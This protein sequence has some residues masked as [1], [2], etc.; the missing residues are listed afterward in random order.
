MKRLKVVSL[1]LGIAAAALL[2]AYPA[3]A[4]NT[5]NQPPGPPAA[6]FSNEEKG[7]QPR[8]VI[9]T[10]VTHCQAFNDGPGTIVFTAGRVG[11]PGKVNNNCRGD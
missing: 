7:H 4:D 8:P 9:H 2:P 6:S 1:T 11:H 3:V 10:F 5:G